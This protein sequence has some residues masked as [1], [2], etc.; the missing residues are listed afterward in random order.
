MRA[1]HNA[2]QL[3]GKTFDRL[4]VVAYGYTKSQKRYWLCKCTCGNEVYV[5]TA[6][7]NNGHTRSC[8]CLNRERITKHGRHNT[9]EYLVWQ[10]MKERCYNKKKA[11]YQRYGARGIT[12]CDRWSGSEGF[13][14]FYTDMGPR[15]EGTTL[16]RI[17]N[18]GPYSPENCRWAT[19]YEQYRNR[20][21]TV[22]W[23]I[24]GVTKCRKDWCRHYGIHTATVDARIKK[25]W[26]VIDALTTPP[27][28]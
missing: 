25:G 13:V 12:V 22:W 19:A 5:H 21:Q 26:S 7:L 15:P 20:R 3:V 2:A 27:N 16:D 10:Q 24:D 6:K 17:D 14:N 1:A 9:S 4:H 23:T 8:G 11:A 28:T 18:N